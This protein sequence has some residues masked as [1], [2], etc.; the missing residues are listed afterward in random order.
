MIKT[1]K[2]CPTVNIRSLKSAFP[3]RRTEE[4]LFVDGKISLVFLLFFRKSW[5][6]HFRNQSGPSGLMRSADTSSIISMEIFIKQ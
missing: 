6:Q 4:K 3:K 1:A 5:M 2:D